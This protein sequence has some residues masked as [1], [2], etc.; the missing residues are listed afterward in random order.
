MIETRPTALSS[1]RVRGHG[2]DVLAIM[3]AAL[4]AVDPAE[5]VRRFVSVEG[6]RLS[7][8]GHVYDLCGL[9]HLYV[10]GAGKASAAMALAVERLLGDRITAGLINVKYGYTS[11]TSIVELNEAGHPLPDERGLRGT[12]RMVQLAREA[13]PRD[14][15]LCLI[16]GGGSALMPFPVTGI[17]LSDVQA[18]TDALLSCGAT[19]NEINAIR[20]HISQV[21]G[22]N[23]ARWAYPAELVSLVLSD[24][25][26]NPLD[27]IASGPTVPDGTTFAEAY[28]VL[29]KYDLSSRVPASILEHIRR[30]VRGE[31]PEN[32]RV[33]DQVFDR[34]T[35]LV[36]GSNDIAASAAV[37]QARQLGYNAMLMSTY[38]E[39]EAREVARVFA[40][41]G[42]EIAS[43]G[44][45]LPAPA[46]VVAGGE[47]T[48]TIRG[49]G[50]G[51]RNQELALAGALAIAGLD[52]VLIVALATDGTDGPTDAGGAVVDGTTVGRAAEA[53][54]S[55]EASLRD[56]DS[57]HFFERLGDLLLTGPTNTNVND[58]TFVFVF[59]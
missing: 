55:A 35:T 13:G 53:G 43:S 50:L 52:N 8:G 32:P 5:A 34:A 2:D 26:G 40:S 54:L 28:E 14:L 45:P 41:I 24:V 18:V 3:T 48:V 4:H 16:S 27:A 21:K 36:V 1:G 49:D 23:L 7:I 31:V 6:N 11:A 20:K 42:R 58:L 33:R 10:I 38:V 15:I 59:E 19:I 46:C 51:G 39:G 30:G 9:D 29:K 22:G 17:S 37:R 12:A 56:N 44:R 57:Y 47:T 25:V